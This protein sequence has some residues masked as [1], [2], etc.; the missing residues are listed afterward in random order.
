MFEWSVYNIYVYN[1]TRFITPTQLAD[2]ILSPNT[3]KP[4]HAYNSAAHHTIYFVYCIVYIN[5]CRNTTTQPRSTQTTQPQTT[6]RPHNTHTGHSLVRRAKCVFHR[7][8]AA[9]TKCAPPPP[10]RLCDF[11]SRPHA[12]PLLDTRD[13]RTRPIRH[14]HTEKKTARTAQLPSASSIPSAPRRRRRTPFRN[15]ARACTSIAFGAVVVVVF[16]PSFAAR[17]LLCGRVV[18]SRLHSLPTFTYTRSTSPC[19]EQR[20]P[21]HNHHK[22]KSPCRATLLAPGLQHNEH[23]THHRQQNSAARTQQAACKKSCVCVCVV[24]PSV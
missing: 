8:P 5:K 14:H 17:S 24:A 13:T 3:H 12:I 4:F 10:P 15:R 20:V 19:G 18:D 6:S 16:D 11:V 1:L 23:P 22:R 2:S 7:C 21:I 9:A